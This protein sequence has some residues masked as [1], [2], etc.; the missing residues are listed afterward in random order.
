MAWTPDEDANILAAIRALG[1]QWALIAQK[2]ERS[3]PRTD[4]VQ[5]AARGEAFTPRCS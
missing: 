2:L 4:A 1:T 5:S 3:A